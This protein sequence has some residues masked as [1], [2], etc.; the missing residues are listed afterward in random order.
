MPRIIVL[1]EPADGP[2]GGIEITYEERVREEHLTSRHHSD[3]LVERLQWAVRDAEE[4]E[5]RDAA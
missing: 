2:A 3:Q 5:R 4:A 1:A